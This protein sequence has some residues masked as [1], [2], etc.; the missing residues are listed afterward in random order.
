[1]VIGM[2]WNSRRRNE[3][4]MELLS[5]EELAASAQEVTQ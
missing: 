5:P 2:V 3:E 4:P 1:M